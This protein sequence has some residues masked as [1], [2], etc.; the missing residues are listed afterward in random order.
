[1]TAPIELPETVEVEIELSKWSMIR[2]RAD[3]S[4]DYLSPIPCPYNYGF[5]PGTLAA[6]GDEVDAVVLGRRAAVGTRV[7]VPVRGVI[8][9]IDDDVE[10]HKVICSDAPLLPA[11]AVGVWRFFRFFGLCKTLLAAARGEQG[12]IRSEGWL[13]WRRVC[14]SSE[15]R[16]L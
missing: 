14:C 13:P 11:E 6:D 9:F 8:G 12:A 7:K 4:I 2:R 15:H 5:I 1:M 10:D 3:G 16:G